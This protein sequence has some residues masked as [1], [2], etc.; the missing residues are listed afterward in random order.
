MAEFLPK[1][2]YDS[3]RK[4]IEARRMNLGWRRTIPPSSIHQAAFGR[5]EAYVKKL[6]LPSDAIKVG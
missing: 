5:G 2:H 1:R 4:G 6:K 3:L